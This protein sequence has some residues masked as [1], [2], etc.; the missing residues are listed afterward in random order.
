VGKTVQGEKVKRRMGKNWLLPQSFPL[1][2][3]SLFEPEG[4]EWQD[5]RHS[6]KECPWREN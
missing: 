2:A 1:Y 6:F 3:F 4:N 5:Y